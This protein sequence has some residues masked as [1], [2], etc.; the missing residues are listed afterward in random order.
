MNHP[1]QKSGNTVK[2]LIEKDVSNKKNKRHH[3]V[4][5]YKKQLVV[6]EGPFYNTGTTQ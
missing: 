5:E 4:P 6:G 3:G 1:I 2:E